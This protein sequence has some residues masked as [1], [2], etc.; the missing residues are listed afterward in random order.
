ML[1]GRRSGRGSTRV[2]LR[3]LAFGATTPSRCST[4]SS[5]SSAKYTG[6]VTLES[7]HLSI[8]IERPFEE[9]RAFSSD[10]ANMQQ[11]AAG[12]SGG[13]ERRAD[14]VWVGPGPGDVGEIVV[15]F[16]ERNPFGVVDH[17]VTLPNGDVVSVPLRVIANADGSEVVF[18][19]FRL[20][21]MTDEQLAED[22]A[23]VEKDLATLKRVLEER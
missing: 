12:L 21:A 8:R 20:P 6:F 4:P 23:A 13:L 18:T 16:A 15:R 9:V 19:L 11:W 22:R 1:R 2:G 3:P 10:P 17:E 14:G 5:L 7:F